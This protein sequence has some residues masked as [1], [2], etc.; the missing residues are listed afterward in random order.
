MSDL[1]D[2]MAAAYGSSPAAPAASP[3]QNELS[4]ISRRGALIGAAAAGGAFWLGWVPGAAAQS[5]NPPQGTGGGGGG[6]GGG[7]EGGGRR[8]KK[9]E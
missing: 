9:K 5:A 2:E 6:G 3:A 7:E 1:F 8:N 4:G